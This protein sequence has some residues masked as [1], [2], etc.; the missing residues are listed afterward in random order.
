[1]RRRRRW[2][3]TRARPAPGGDGIVSATADFSVNFAAADFGTDGAGSATLCAGADRR[4]VASGLFALEAA[5]TRGDGDGIGQGA[6]IV[7][8]KVG[9][10][11]HRPGRRCD[12]LHDQR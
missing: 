3:W 9:D 12:L 8:N 11:I 6:S 10:D 7:L 1:M 2:F 5:D 4:D